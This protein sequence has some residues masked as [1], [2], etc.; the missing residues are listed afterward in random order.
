MFCGMR[1]KHD[2]RLQIMLPADRRQQLDEFATECG[3][4]ASDLARCAIAE[5][6]ERRSLTLKA[7]PEMVGGR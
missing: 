2:A 5:M 7:P 3:L 4:S 1:I 6:L